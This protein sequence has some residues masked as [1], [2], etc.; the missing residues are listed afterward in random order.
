[1]TGRPLVMPPPWRIVALV[2]ALICVVIVTRNIFNEAHQVIGWAV[3]ASLVALML[4][5]VVQGMDRVMPRAL[6]IVLTFLMVIV[7][8]AGLAWLYSSSV[9][10]QV[11]QIQESGP[12]IAEE[13]EQR[14]DRVGEIARE[15][16]LVDQVTELTDRLDERTGSGS[17]AIRSAALSAPPYFVS[18]IL[19]IFLLLFGPS[20]INGG[21]DQLSPDR[22]DRYRPALNEAAR[23]TQAYVWASIAQGLVSGVFIWI[24]ATMLDLPA[25]GLLALFGAIAA[26]LPYL[27]IFVGWLP[28]LL[29]G[30]GVASDV[31]VVLVAAVALTLQVVEAFWWRRRVDERSL[32]VGPAVPVVVAIL[33]YGIYGIGGALYGCVLAVLALAVA[34]QLWPGPEL[35]TPLTD[36]DT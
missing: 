20:M 33:G 9:L 12:S 8:G 21:L 28:V 17:D 34:D 25:V 19:T 30:I 2:T 18:M 5:P 26:L 16:G 3:A 36:T 11:E 27:G 22:R 35:P 10:D 14:G 13:I 6:A 15:I 1:M 4:S 7:L 24:V 29:L 31:E 23:R 32:H